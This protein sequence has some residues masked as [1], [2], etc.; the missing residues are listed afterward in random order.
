M[1]YLAHSARPALGISAQEYH[2]HVSNVVGAAAEKAVNVARY[3]PT[4][5]ELLRSAVRIA[6][7]FHDLSKLDEQNQQVFKTGRGRLPVSHVDAGV[8]HVLSGSIDRLQQAA[9][10]LIYAH[11][12]GLPSLPEENAKGAGNVFRDDSLTETGLSHSVHTDGHLV[13]Y[14]DRHTTSIGDLPPLKY[15]DGKPAVTPLF[16]RLALSCLVDADHS[17]TARHYEDPVAA[18]PTLLNPSRRLELLNRH[19]E[20][21]S[22][23]KHDDRNRLRSAI[24]QKCRDANFSER[25]IACDSPVGSGKTTAIMAHLLKVADARSL[26]RVIV[27][28]PFTNII[29][30]SVEVYR[31]AL[32]QADEDTSDIVA[33]HHHRAECDDPSSRQFAFLWRAPVVV[34]TAVQFFET[35]AARKPAALRKLHQVP[36]SAIFID[37]SHAALPAHLWPQAWKWLQD[38]EQSW[39]CHVVFGSGSLNRFWGLKDFVDPP[40]KLPELVRQSV[41]EDSTRAE[42]RRISYRSHPDPLDLKGLAEFIG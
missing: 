42:S 22:R 24:Y 40:A 18:E 20:Q 25:M 26:R 32:V 33:A 3:S 27:V 28:L 29:D 7:E 10:V 16:L 6:A 4:Y 8:A 9:A 19:V 14:R 30:Q 17:D 34:T 2:E 39:S 23:G 12:V 38:L 31:K 15:P 1:S 21:L 5:G 36:G 35:L 37:E 11:H 13:T 41:R